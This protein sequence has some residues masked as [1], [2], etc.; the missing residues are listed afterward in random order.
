[1]KG[2][3]QRKPHPCLSQLLR[4][5]SATVTPPSVFHSD[6][7]QEEVI[8]VM[9]MS[10]GDD[11]QVGPHGE[12]FVGNPGRTNKTLRQC[13]HRGREKEGEE[14]TNDNE[15]RIKC[16]PN[17]GNLFSHYCCLFFKDPWSRYFFCCYCSSALR[18]F[19][20][21]RPPAINTC[22]FTPLFFTLQRRKKN[23]E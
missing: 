15:N 12:P 10:R 17:R 18:I 11:R 4:L 2:Q 7:V 22:V 5:T 8:S 3:K 19:D 1:M 23:N 20:G 16:H 14:K 21:T 9:Q 13:S 6:R